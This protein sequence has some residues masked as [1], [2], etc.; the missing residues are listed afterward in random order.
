MGANEALRKTALA[1][2]LRAEAY[3]YGYQQEWCGIPI[4]RL[5][6]DI[7]IFQEI[8]WRVKPRFVIETGV[9]RA[10]SLV[11]AASLM[12]MTQLKPRVLG[13]DIKIFPHAREALLLSPFASGIQLWEGDSA[14]ERARLAVSDFVRSTPDQGPGILV[15]D[16][17]HSH[18]HVLQELQ[19]H[20]PLMP[21]GSLILV[22]DT[23][24]E[25]FPAGHYPDRPWDRGNSPLT[26]VRTFLREN[27]GFRLADEWARRGLVTEFR[28]GIIERTG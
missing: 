21:R 20:A 28:D 4:I 22:A 17:D 9:A 12:A 11:L 5:P 14:S 25:E 26:A 3:A 2:Q 19:L 6:D 18:S 27:P 16:S 1:L 8:V 23:L 15:L 10:G 24:I 13:L 7:V